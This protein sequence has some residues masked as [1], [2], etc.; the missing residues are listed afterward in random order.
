MLAASALAA[1]ALAT[2][3]LAAEVVWCVRKLLHGKKLLKVEL[4]LLK[5]ASP[6]A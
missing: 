4:Q 1:P 6:K 3:A 5:R 2:L